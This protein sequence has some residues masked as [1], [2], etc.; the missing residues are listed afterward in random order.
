MKRR[1]DKYE[2]FDPSLHRAEIDVTG[3][4]AFAEKHTGYYASDWNGSLLVAWC[5]QRAIPTTCR[6][7]TLAFEELSAD[8]MLEAAPKRNPAA[9]RRSGGIIQALAVESEQELAALAKLKD[10]PSLSDATRRKRDV[11]LRR[12]A[13]A[14]RTAFR[15]PGSGDQQKVVI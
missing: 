15:R 11:T 13:V 5:R 3:A 8:G 2:D 7:L 10:D 9:G 12:L 4:E 6:N 14:Q 1:L